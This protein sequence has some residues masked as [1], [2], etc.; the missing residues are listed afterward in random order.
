M[1]SSLQ[2][3]TPVEPDDQACDP[4]G[5]QRMLAEEACIT[6]MAVLGGALCLIALLLVLRLIYWV[7]VWQETMM[8]L[9]VFG[10]S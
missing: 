3:T 5:R 9:P 1:A 4:T 7:W 2:H 10:A 6:G 8:V